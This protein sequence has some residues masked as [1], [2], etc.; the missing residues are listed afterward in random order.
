[1]KDLQF[2]DILVRQD[3]PLNRASVYVNGRWS[4][5]SLITPTRI[6]GEQAFYLMNYPFGIMKAGTKN[7][8][9]YAVKGA[10]GDY[11]SRDQRGFLALVTASNYALLFPGPQ[12]LPIAAPTSEQLKDPNF[13]TKTQAESVDKDSDKVLIG[14]REFTLPSTQKKTITIIETPTG[15]AQ[16]YYDSSGGAVIYDYD[17]EQMVEVDVPDKPY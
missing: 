10:P 4:F 1:M 13:L 12:Q 16:A 8:S 2:K 17:L 9:K 15:Q 11:I 3:L 7:P 5:A 14:D 6:T